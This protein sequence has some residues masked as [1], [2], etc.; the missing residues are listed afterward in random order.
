M[1]KLVAI[2]LA[3]VG[4]DDEL[5]VVSVQEVLGDV[6]PPVAASSPHFVGYAAVLRHGVTPQ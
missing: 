2:L 5:H 3:L 4:A 1:A 6:W